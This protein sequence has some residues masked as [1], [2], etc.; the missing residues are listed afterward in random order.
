[1]WSIKIMTCVPDTHLSINRYIEAVLA[2]HARTSVETGDE[3]SLDDCTL[4]YARPRDERAS[5]RAC[6]DGGA[7]ALLW[8]SILPK[9][10]CITRRVPGECQTC[11]WLPTLGSRAVALR[12][13]R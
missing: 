9:S 13:E 6:M 5:W 3:L 1:M 8:C 7:V 2:G 11:S 10:D 4:S 12:R